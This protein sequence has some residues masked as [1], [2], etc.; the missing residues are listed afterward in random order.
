MN[1]NNS[2]YEV[3]RNNALVKGLSSG[4]LET[5]YNAGELV[6]VGAGDLLIQEGQGSNYLYLVLS[7]KL[8]IYHPDIQENFTLALCN[9][10]EYVGEYAFI[11]AEPASATVKVTQPSEF[12]RIRHE[13]AKLL[14]KSDADMGQVVYRNLLTNL[15]TRLRS[16]DKEFDNFLLIF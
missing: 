4:Q 16:M 2:T 6:S 1:M 3:L 9:P 14:F 13:N 8:E 7:G 11:D 10:G 15:V 5:F 12:F